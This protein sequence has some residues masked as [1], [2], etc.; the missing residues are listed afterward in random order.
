[1]M[2]IGHGIPKALEFS[3]KAAHF[4]DPLGVGST[5]S[6]SLAIFG[7]V[8]GSALLIVGLVTRGAAVPFVITMLVAAVVVHAGDPWAQKE[9]ALLYAVAGLALMGTGAG[10]FSVDRL[11]WPEK[12]RED[13][14]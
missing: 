14:A 11:L 2:L 12:P 8:V 5:A 6:L 4:P 9:L 3:E 1:M 10:R 7:E 13:A